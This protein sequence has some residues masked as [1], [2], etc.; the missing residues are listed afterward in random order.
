MGWVE[1]GVCV[2][3]VTVTTRKDDRQR[4]P[5]A[6]AGRCQHHWVL[7][8]SSGRVT[9]GVCRLCGARKKF[10]N[11]FGDCVQA[12]EQE[13]EAWLSRQSD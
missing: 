5:T 7:D 1:K 11:Y 12:D 2:M 4:Q 9:E 3:A 13:Y 10:M 8:N 6:E